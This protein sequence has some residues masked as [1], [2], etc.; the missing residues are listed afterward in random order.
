ML[1]MENPAISMC[2]FAFVLI[3]LRAFA[4]VSD[5][6]LIPGSRSVV[7]VARWLPMTPRRT[8]LMRHPVIAGVRAST[9]KSARRCWRKPC[10][11]SPQ[12]RTSQKRENLSALGR[13]LVH[14]NNWLPVRSAHRHKIEKSALVIRGVRQREPRMLPEY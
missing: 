2:R 12:K 11:L 3:S 5:T 8:V 1:R 10:P 6:N 13:R 7:A 4:G 9:H 14:R